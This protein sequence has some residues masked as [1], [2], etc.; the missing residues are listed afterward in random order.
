MTDHVIVW[1]FDTPTVRA[2][3]RCNAG[4]ESA[5][6]NMPTCDCDEWEDE[7]RDEQGWFHTIEQYGTDAE[8]DGDETVVHRH[9]RPVDCNICTWLNES[10]IEEC[11]GGLHHF[12][13]AVTPIK[14]HWASPG[15]DWEPAK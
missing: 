4:P 8:A 5:C 12:E 3:A 1:T 10:D 7:Q 9:D 2:E 14:T 6:R 11:A 15:Y 13:L